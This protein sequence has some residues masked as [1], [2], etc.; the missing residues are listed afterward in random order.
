MPII[1]EE[2]FVRCKQCGHEAATG[3]R[4]NEAGLREDPPGERAITCHCCGRREVYGDRDYYHRTVDDDRV[5][6]NA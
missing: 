1:D 3:I 5:R 2:L 6:A 4:R